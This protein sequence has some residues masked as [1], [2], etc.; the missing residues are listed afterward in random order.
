MEDESTSLRNK[1]K[2][3]NRLSLG[4]TPNGNTTDRECLEDL[5]RERERIAFENDYNEINQE[6]EDMLEQMDSSRYL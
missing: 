5:E 3:M 2:N 4:T 1:I 6:M